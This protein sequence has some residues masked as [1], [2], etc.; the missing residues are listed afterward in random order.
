MG[1]YNS[2]SGY[3]DEF[4]ILVVIPIQTMGFYNSFG[5]TA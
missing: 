1:F 4:D 5:Q 2:C 3:D